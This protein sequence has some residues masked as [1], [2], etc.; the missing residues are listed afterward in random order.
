MRTISNR[1]DRRPGLAL[2]L[3]FSVAACGADGESE[4]WATGGP[5][6]VAQSEA[7]LATYNMND[8]EPWPSNLSICFTRTGTLSSSLYAQ[9][10]PDIM[11]ALNA[12]WGAASALDFTALPGRAGTGARGRA[13]PAHTDR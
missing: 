13:R 9:A 1:M 12:T 4:P 6:S 11:A 8:W 3:A 2:V 10:K 7:A 5:E